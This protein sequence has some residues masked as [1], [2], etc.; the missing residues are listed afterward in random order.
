MIRLNVQA[1]VSIDPSTINHVETVTKA[2]SNTANT[3]AEL[4]GTIINGEQPKSPAPM[5]D[6]M[7]NSIAPAAVPLSGLMYT[8]VSRQSEVT[9]F[10][11]G[12]VEPQS[13]IVS[14]KP[15]ELS[16]AQTPIQQ[17]GNKSTPPIPV[18]RIRTS[19]RGHTSKAEIVTSTK[20][21]TNP[22]EVL[23]LSVKDQSSALPATLPRSNTVGQLGQDTL[24]MHTVENG[25]V[26]V[27]ANSVMERQRS[28]TLPRRPPIAR[29]NL[30]GSGG[31]GATTELQ[32]LL[33]KRR[34]WEQ[35]DS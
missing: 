3:S 34:Q 31:G 10:S 23:T 33:A 29:K 6:V 9:Q 26:S 24:H 13:V 17:I 35:N 7:S 16:K 12:S 15:P 25:A 27:T 22:I 32:A 21:S 2:S 14:G 20:A 30:P 8:D 18:P 28:Q 11:N 1:A 19:P 4:L 5:Q